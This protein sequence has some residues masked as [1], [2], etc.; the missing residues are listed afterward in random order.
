MRKIEH[1]L[2]YWLMI[3]ILFDFKVY[4]SNL[5]TLNFISYNETGNKTWPKKNGHTE[6]LSEISDSKQSGAQL[7]LTRHV[8]PHLPINQENLLKRDCQRDTYW[9]LYAGKAPPSTE[10]KMIQEAAWLSVSKPRIN[11]ISQLGNL[12]YSDRQSFF[13]LFVMAVAPWSYPH[14]Q[15]R[16]LMVSKRQPVPLLQSWSAQLGK[17]TW[18]VWL[19]HSHWSR[20]CCPKPESLDH[21]GSIE[22]LA[23]PPVS[24]TGSCSRQV[25]EARQT[26]PAKILLNLLSCFHPSLDLKY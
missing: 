14:H 10:E 16:K 25:M 20:W 15:G 24:N 3:N 19:C 13:I 11:R 12:Q 5:S 4:S 7:R 2:L 18:E 21:Q 6:V 9:D 8:H 17:C 23:A 22:K 1:T 26:F